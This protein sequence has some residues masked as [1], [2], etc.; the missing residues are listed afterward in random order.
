M[1]TTAIGGRLT[2]A[3]LD[4]VNGGEGNLSPTI[5]DDADLEAV[6]GGV[7]LATTMYRLGIEGLYQASKAAGHQR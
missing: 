2:D 6:S 3:K 1:Y 5:L 4:E 7:T